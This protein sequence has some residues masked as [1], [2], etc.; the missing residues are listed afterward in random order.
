MKKY[1]LS[2][3]WIKENGEKIKEAYSSAGARGY[4]VSSKSDVLKLLKLIDPR[5][6]NKENAEIF[7]KILQL[8]AHG[9][10]KRFELKPKTQSKIVH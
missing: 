7:S 10:K 9:I 5:N 1:E 3:E 2:K 4:D 8:F 6:A